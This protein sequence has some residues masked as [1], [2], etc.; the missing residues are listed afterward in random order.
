MNNNDSILPKIIAVMFILTIIC[1]SFFID[2]GDDSSTSS[3]PNKTT[4]AS[5]S[6][7]D[8]VIEV[9]ELEEKIQNYKTCVED[10][11]YTVDNALSE[12]K[13]PANNN[14][15]NSAIDTIEGVDWCGL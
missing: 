4:V 10:I 3:S 8:R 14:D 13:Y 7:D 11:R 2:F 12:I 15:Y 1:F 5:P 6:Y 9:M